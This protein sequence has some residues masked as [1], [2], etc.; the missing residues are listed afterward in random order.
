MRN[1]R[2]ITPS[3]IIA[4]IEAMMSEAQHAITDK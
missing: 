3:E 2:E 4:L 1:I